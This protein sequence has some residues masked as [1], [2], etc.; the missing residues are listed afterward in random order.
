MMMMMSGGR[1]V[2]VLNADPTLAAVAHKYLTTPAT[3]VACERLF[4]VSVNIVSKASLSPKNVN[5]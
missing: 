1:L 5:K 4:S 2:L 3:T